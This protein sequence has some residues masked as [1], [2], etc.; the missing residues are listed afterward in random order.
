MKIFSSGAILLAAIGALA[1]TIPSYAQTQTRRTS[2]PAAPVYEKSKEITVDGTVESMVTNPAAGSLMGAHVM[3]A[4]PSEEVDGHVG[5][6]ATR[7]SN[8][9]TLTPGERVQMVGVMTTMASGNRLFLVRT[10]QA[11]SHLY[12]IRN[13]HGFLIRPATTPEQGGQL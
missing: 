7:G 2:T 11:G 10:I 13:A 3:V 4:T 1:I 5:I 9:M 8:P 6:Y 12:T